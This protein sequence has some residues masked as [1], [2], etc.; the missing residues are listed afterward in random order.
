M[1][2]VDYFLADFQFTRGTLLFNDNNI[3]LRTNWS[4]D[5]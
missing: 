5:T 3:D 4:S 2:I 1:I